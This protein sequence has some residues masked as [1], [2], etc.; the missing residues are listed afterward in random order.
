V[1]TIK[2]RAIPKHA[3]AM[4]KRFEGFAE[5]P[6]KDT[7][8]IPTIGYGFNLKAHP[9]I[10]Q[11]KTMGQD[12]IT[13]EEAD[14]LFVP[15]YNEAWDRAEEFAGPEV[16]GAL[17]PKRK[18]ILA[19]MSYNLTNKLFGFEE[20]QK[21]LRSNDAAGVKREMKDSAWYE[22]VGNRSKAHIREW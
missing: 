10:L 3:M 16:F 7:K 2:T 5:S 9:E 15:L 1:S 21:A 13:Q 12:Y 4:T 18:A 20:M 11:N 8:G 17:S 19:D 14:E 6:Y 22:Q